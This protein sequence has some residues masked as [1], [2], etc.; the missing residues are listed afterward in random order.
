MVKTYHI[1][2]KVGVDQYLLPSWIY[3]FVLQVLGLALDNAS[4]NDTLT[5]HLA[6][7]VPSFDGSSSRIRCFN[8]VVNLVAKAIL[9]PFKKGTER[10]FE[11]IWDDSSDDDSGSEDDDEGVIDGASIILDGDGDESDENEVNEQDD[12]EALRA[13]VEPIEVARLSE[14]AEPI[15]LALQKVSV[16]SHIETRL[17]H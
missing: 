14:E 15:A 17:L 5:D 3:K 10:E 2:D 11:A 9:R 16:S 8:H 1:G 7:T 13:V 4:N 6:A 12:E